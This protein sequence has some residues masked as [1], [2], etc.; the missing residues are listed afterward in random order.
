MFSRVRPLAALLPLLV[1]GPWGCGPADAPVVRD[2]G[3][4]QADTAEPGGAAD[5]ADPGPRLITSPIV[6]PTGAEAG[7]EDADAD[8]IEAALDCDDADPTVWTAHD[9]YEGDLSGS[10]DGF[11]DGFCSRTLD[12]DLDLSTA[13]AESVRA[14]TCLIEVTGY[15]Y[16]KG[17]PS[18]TSLDGLAGLATLR[19]GLTVTGNASLCADEVE[20]LI[21]QLTSFSGDTEATDND[22]R[23][24]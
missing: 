15:V 23:C 2:P 20:A 13:S 11:C 16:V 9:T 12:G 10:P 14:L 6:A 18:L 22:G 7:P 21:A 24:P 3:P 17:N 5:T 4:E 1:A 8:G 19:D